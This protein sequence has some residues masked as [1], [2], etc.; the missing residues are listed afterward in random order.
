MKKKNIIV[1]LLLLIPFLFVCG[2][3]TWIILKEK[4][5]ILNYKPAD[6]LNK[7]IT[8]TQ[9]TTYSGKEQT[10]E[11]STKLVNFGELKFE[12]KEYG[13]SNDYFIEGKP[14]NV[15]HY[16]VR[17]SVKDLDNSESIT[18]T[19]DFTIDPFELEL[20]KDIIEI[21]YDS[22]SRIWENSASEEN[23]ISYKI[24]TNLKFKDKLNLT[25]NDINILGMH[26]G[27]FA[28][29]N[30]NYI[31]DLKNVQ[32]LD[33]NNNDITGLTDYTNVVG[34]TY[35][36]TVKITNKNFKIKGSTDNTI[37]FI[38]KYKTA[39]I[40]STYYTI[41]DAISKS[42]NI[43]FAGNSNSST[44]F[45]Y[46]AFSS[47]QESV[48]LNF[49]LV[50]TYT[51]IFT[52]KSRQLTVPYSSENKNYDK[53]N[54]PSNKNVYSALFIPTG[55]TLT[56]DSSSKIVIAAFIGFNMSLGTTISTQKGVINNQGK[57]ILESK[58]ELLS[59][60]FLKGKYGSVIANSDSIVQDCLNIF[61]WPGGNVG[62]QIVGD[63]FP[64]NAWACHNI[65]CELIINS[66][67]YFKVFMHVR[68]KILL[69]ES[70]YDT[71]AIVVGKESDNCLFY[72]N[73]SSSYIIKKVTK[74]NSWSEESTNYKALFQI[75]GNNQIQGQ[76]DVFEIYGDY[77]D[78][79][80]KAS[81]SVIS[82]ETSLNKPITIG[83]MDI[84]LKESTNLTLAKSDF[85]FLPGSKLIIE[86]NAIL[87]IEEKELDLTFTKWNDLK[88]EASSDGSK[89]PG[90]WVD[91]IDSSFIN[92]GTFINKGKIGG[93]I[94][95]TLSGAK[96]INT[97]QVTSSY[98][99]YKAI[100]EPYYST[101][102]A[103]L[104]A[105]ILISTDSFQLQKMYA[106]TYFSKN[107]AW[108]SESADIEF[109]S[110]G[111]SVVNPKT[112]KKI[113]ANGYII[114]SDDVSP[115]PEREHYTFDDWYYDEN[116]TIKA[117][118]QT[119]FVTTK[120]YA[121]WIPI[122]YDIIYE[123]SYVDCS[124]D[125]SNLIINNELKINFRDGLSLNKAIDGNLS[126]DMWYLDSEFKNPVSKITPS[127]LTEYFNTTTN[128][129]TIYGRFYPEGTETYTIT[130]ETNN[131]EIEL[132]PE[133][134]ISVNASSY[135]LP[136][137][138][139]GRNNNL[140]YSQYFEGWYTTST[141]D[142]GTEFNSE[143]I[144][145]SSITLYGKWT[146]KNKLQLLLSDIEI[147]FIYYHNPYSFIIPAFTNKQIE[148]I[149][150]LA[151]NKTIVG[152]EFDDGTLCNEGDSITLTNQEKAT[153]IVKK[154]STLK[155]SFGEGAD[156]TLTYT[157]YYVDNNGKCKKGTKELSNNGETLEVFEGG[158]YTTN[159]VASTGFENPTATPET[160][161]IAESDE[162][163]KFTAKKSGEGCVLPDTLITMA[164]GTKKKVED[165]TANDILLVFN[166]ETGRY[167][168]A[169][170]IFNDSEM[171]QLF[172]IINLKFSNGKIIKVISE[173]G[174]FDL[175]L[176]KYVYITE[177]N[178]KDYV[179]HRFYSAE[180][181][182]T[183]YKENEVILED[184]YITT[185][186]TRCYSP[187]TEYHLN[188][189]VEDLL[190]MPG[191]I[192]GLFNI[193]DYDSTLKY[194]EEKMN[195]DIE[196]YGLFSYEDFK[197]LVPYEIYCLFPT[198]YF[199]V[200]IAKNLLTMEQ[201]QYY[202]DR[203]LPLM[204]ERN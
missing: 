174:F 132:S 67:A 71:T 65:S 39:M 84:I 50:A 178:Y 115:I 74:A 164:D 33:V 183:T 103:T 8:D 80:L 9:I 81:I 68:V 138:G 129:L 177:N 134:I 15:G 60:G 176:M 102:T 83:Y 153:L 143:N 17:I 182:G 34:S 88:N 119:I 58:A 179:G 154:Q 114:S 18:R 152:W 202:I 89:F 19:V 127:I 61:D 158:T 192:E 190:S 44:S 142:E 149:N 172:T 169:R 5:V 166:H 85:L 101:K 13:L 2:M 87:T 137:L 198:K 131:S 185:E 57:I 59:Y 16:I 199:K 82:L 23:S 7:Y 133:E 117:E 157:G 37:N 98:V 31:N 91:K 6:V 111:G 4:G 93:F 35:L 55:I 30:P 79:K 150:L 167:D 36:T 14:I 77:K 148:M 160:G 51:N 165:I 28:Y 47:L 106:G 204:E 49:N 62:S 46:T 168:F 188:Y 75:T 32:K 159:P 26:D 141:F 21:G 40:G 144:I 63:V 54:T 107:G 22:T 112:D 191:G 193:F 189:F 108:Y 73:S 146:N 203:Y 145:N 72:S 104:T 56:I 25:N 195:N 10:P 130:Y 69:S 161:T 38:V 70:S 125:K 3:S 90:N 126:F 170:V 181:D 163:V 173:H 128:T 29:G 100:K 53:G 1:I 86:K 64:T 120:L 52:L 45:V 156:G 78:N 105:N 11:A 110:N 97:G 187:V 118:G 20:S 92:D 151:P 109:E 113:G 186:M 116:L 147:M 43:T 99:I 136:N 196:K 135:I 197:D 171:Y 24:K 200:A 155:I 180:W 184:A 121:K 27:T 48:I 139:E 94:D 162:E 175:D 42:G 12:Y 122:E 41:E 76:R 66:N 194:D 95:T 124:S 140:D 96:I 201:I 123:I